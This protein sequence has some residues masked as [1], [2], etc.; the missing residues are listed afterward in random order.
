MLRVGG[1]AAEQ[2]VLTPMIVFADIVQDHRIALE[3]TGFRHQPNL[4]LFE[5]MPCT[6]WPGSLFGGQRTVK[7]TSEG[8]EMEPR[9]ACMVDYSVFITSSWDFFLRAP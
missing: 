7:M 9:M 5:E 1:T 4:L 8:N 2:L 3:I 6:V